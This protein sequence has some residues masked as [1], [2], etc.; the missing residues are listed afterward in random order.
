MK[1]TLRLILALIFVGVIS[2]TAVLLSR[3]GVGGL[4]VDFTSDNLYTLSDGT[5]GI[6]GKLN[7]TVTLK[8]YYARVAAMKGPDQIRFWN[9]YY[10]Y[11]R[12][13]LQEYVRLSDGKVKLELIDPRTYSADEEEAIRN[14][15]KRFPISDDESFYFGML[16]STELGKD[17]VIEFFEPNRQELVEYDVSKIISSLMQRKKRKVGIVSSLPVMG[18]ANMSPYM[19]QMMRMQGRQPDPPWT[20][21][22]Q[23]QMDY[24]VENLKLDDTHEIPED[25]DFLMVIHP[26]NLGQKARFAIDQF[27]MKGGKLMVFVD[28]HCLADRPPRDPRNPYA[29]LSHQAGSDLN[30]LLINWGVVVATKKIT[31]D[32]AVATKTGRPPQAFL[33]YLTLNSECVNS[34]EA[35]VAKLNDIRMLFAGAISRHGGYATFRPLLSTTKTGSTWIPADATSLNMPDAQKIQKEVRDGTEPVIL[36]CLLT[37]KFT[38]NFPTG[39]EIERDSPD[40]PDTQPATQPATQPDTQP[41]T[42][43]AKQPKDKKKR[44][45]PIKETAKDSGAM[46]LVVSDVDIMTDMLCYD[47]SFF[48][49]AQSGSNVPFVLNALE[50]LS[51]SDDLISIRSRGRFI[52]PFT[53]LDEIERE[54]DRQTQEEID[55]VNTKIKGY[56]SEL[57]ALGKK[58]DSEQDVAMLQE[59]VLAKRRQIEADIT[60]A[61]RQLR[62]LKSI[63]REKVEA[64]ERS[65]ERLNVFAAPAILLLIAIV[66]WL[67]RYFRAKH[68]AAQ[69]A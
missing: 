60:A 50:F 8:L 67:V 65:L 2:I 37:G 40:E 32:R 54:T 22:R 7:Q 28:P 58:S 48:G 63:R 51:G 16:A 59:A 5:R 55:A 35:M 45:E 36:A 12:D 4:Q 15:I 53:V 57:D 41:A 56:Q 47:S 19:M 44:I 46:V 43:P 38:T 13:L 64:L 23:M 25:I 18:P 42:Q 24:E 26:K 20:I 52:R 6:L 11:V 69:R 29:G 9:N 61:N 49:M 17:E 14:G 68:Y 33:P 62:D 3:K 66:L 27:V 31:V 10:L 39:I 1:T 34:S 30:N 21:T